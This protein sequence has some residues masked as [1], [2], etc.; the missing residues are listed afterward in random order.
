MVRLR[1]SLVPGRQAKRLSG[2]KCLAWAATC[3]VVATSG[4]QLTATL[5]SPEALT[6]TRTSRRPLGGKIWPSATPSGERTQTAEKWPVLKCAV[7]RQPFME[8]SGGGWWVGG[9]TPTS[10]AET[11][12]LRH[13]RENL[14]EQGHNVPAGQRSWKKGATESP[15]RNPIRLLSPTFTQLVVLPLSC[16]PLLHCTSAASDYLTRH[17]L[18]VCQALLKHSGRS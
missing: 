2:L 6:A 15:G 12:R 13:W 17:M 7:G 1:S 10:R 16:V 3:Q 4:P 8:G 11:T 5:M 14:G 9:V 18:P